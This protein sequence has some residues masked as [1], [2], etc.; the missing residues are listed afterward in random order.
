MARHSPSH[1]NLDPMSRSQSSSSIRS[2]LTIDSSRSTTSS[3]KRRGLLGK[4]GT[5]VQSI[6]RRF[7]RSRT[8]LTEMQIQI[9]LAMT[10]FTREEVVKWHED[11]ITNYPNGYMTRKQFVSMYKSLCPKSDPERFA[12]HIF[13]A[14]DLDRSNT[15]DFH[16]FLVGLSMTSTTSSIRD[17]LQWIFHVFDID[18]NGILTRRECLE[19]IEIF[20]RFN[21]SLQGDTSNP[22]NDQLIIAAK[23]SMMNIFDNVGDIHND[24][25][26]M[27]Q[28]V[29]GCL[30]DDL[31]SQL[32][33][34]GSATTLTNTHD[35][36][37]AST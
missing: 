11:F 25:L 24:K 7:S 32:L 22:N 36:S 16:E 4:L 31:I 20:V 21:Q 34:P 8:T 30:K 6:F 19:I 27:S 28:F 13:R 15:V 35:N 10:N 37:T 26:T 23:R 1:L 12:R 2:N 18:G 14:F 17:K 9:L 3:Q 33:E 5:G 29:E